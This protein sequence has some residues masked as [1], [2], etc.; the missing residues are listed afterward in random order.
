MSPAARVD[1]RATRH[2][3]QLDIAYRTLIRP[4]EY[5]VARRDV[6]NTHRA[7]VHAVAL[8]RAEDITVPGDALDRDARQRVHGRP[9]YRRE[10]RYRRRSVGRHQHVRARW[11]EPELTVRMTLDREVDG[12]RGC[13]RDLAVGARILII[14]REP[15]AICAR[16]ARVH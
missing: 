10:V 14:E 12:A 13:C 2:A 9:V 5:D 11:L 8:V 3:C 1:S 6:G 7:V 15:A 4:I 16:V